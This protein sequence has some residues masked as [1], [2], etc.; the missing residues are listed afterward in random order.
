MRFGSAAALLLAFATAC[1]TAPKLDVQ[2][3]ERTIRGLDEQLG[4]LVAKH[5]TAGI[6]A[7][8]AGDAVVMPANAPAA[9]DAAAIRA[10]WAGLLSL[11]GVSLALTPEKVEVSAAG[12]LA[13]E[14]GSDMLE[15]DTPQGHIKDTSKYL[16]VWR[17]VNGSWK[18]AYDIWNEN[19]PPAPPPAEAPAKAKP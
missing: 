13:A 4:A 5:D 18:I 10:V 3:E 15:F 8:Y 2:A 1:N 7:M 11:P 14:A 12:D 19:A 9:R 17:K 16:V 6:V